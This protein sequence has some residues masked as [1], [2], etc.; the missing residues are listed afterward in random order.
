MQ[1]AKKIQNRHASKIESI[2]CARCIQQRSEQ[3]AMP[4]AAPFPP[5]PALR[6]H[7][8]FRVNES[9]LKPVACWHS[10]YWTGCYD[11]GV[12]RATAGADCSQR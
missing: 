6:L 9:T 7:F 12:L 1:M 4:A 10:F 3:L 11:E 5:A 2:N 8:Q